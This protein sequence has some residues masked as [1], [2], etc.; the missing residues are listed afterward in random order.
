M[1]CS[2][3]DF[4]SYKC[5]YHIYLPW[6]TKFSWED[7]SQLT[8]KLVSIDK[9]L[10]PEILQLW[11]LGIKTTGCCCGHGKESAFIGVQKTDIEKMKK[12]GYKVRFNP[13]RPN[14]KDSFIPKTILQYDNTKITEI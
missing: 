10:L 1:K 7:D 13:C 6:L 14:D 5:C 4:Q 2:D 9:C 11:E 3:I 12:L 8:P